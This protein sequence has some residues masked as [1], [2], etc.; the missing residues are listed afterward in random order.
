LTSGRATSTARF[1]RRAATASRSRP[2]LYGIAS[3]ISGD[4]D[5]FAATRE[6]AERTLAEILWDEPSLAEL[7]W[8]EP[9]DLLDRCAN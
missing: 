1:R 7:I 3:A 5:D 6:E 9:V 4:I 8:V 2:Q